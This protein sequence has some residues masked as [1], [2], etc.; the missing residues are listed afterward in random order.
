MNQTICKKMKQYTPQPI[1]TKEVTL[2]DELTELVE[3]M[4]KNVHEV[5]AETRIAQGWTYGTERNDQRKHHP[6]LIPYEEL[7]EEERAYDRN[8]AIGTLKLIQKL[9]FKITR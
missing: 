3:A 8:T 6:C 1:D 5:W 2:P 9:G 7:S 4:A